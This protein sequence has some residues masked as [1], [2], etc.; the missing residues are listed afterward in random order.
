[1]TPPKIKVVLIE[2]DPMV[3]EVNRQ[4]VES[5]EGYVV[6]GTAGNG[7][8]GLTLIEELAPD[9]VLM[10]IYMPLMDGLQTIKQ[11]RAAHHAVDVIAITAAKDASS[12]RQ[13]VRGGV[14]DY[15]I[16]PFKFDRVKQALEKYKSFRTQLKNDDAMSQTELDLLLRGRAAVD[17]EKAENGGSF[18]WEE[19][20]PK[21]LNIVTCKQVVDFMSKC[22]VSLSAEEVSVGVGIARVTARRY[23]EFLEKSGKLQLE[24]RYGGVGR[25]INRYHY[26]P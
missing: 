17:V 18:G 8:E 2:D 22:A 20:I 21:G 19:H 5:V 26:K 6:V 10:D 4:F 24:V 9:L 3:Q 14:V 23:L 13:M 25:P 15:I 7:I 11:I 16:K 1:L 12:I